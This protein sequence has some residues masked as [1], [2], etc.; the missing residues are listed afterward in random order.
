MDLEKMNMSSPGGEWGSQ[1]KVHPDRGNDGYQVSRRQE[2]ENLSVEIQGLTQKIMHFLVEKAKKREER[3]GDEGRGE[4]MPFDAGDTSVSVLPA[5]L[6]NIQELIQKAAKQAAWKWISVLAHRSHRVSSRET[7]KSFRLK[8]P[9]LNSS[10][11]YAFFSSRPFF[12]TFISGI[13]KRAGI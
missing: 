1:G 8:C 6:S 5:L 9:T 11:L 4:K 12:P 2:I 3:K 13:G 10:F 7:Q